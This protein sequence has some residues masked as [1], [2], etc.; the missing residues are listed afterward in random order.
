MMVRGVVKSMRAVAGETPAENGRP[1]Q[2]WQFL[3]LEVHDF[4]A[5][6][7]SCQLRHDDPKY[8]EYSPLSPKKPIQ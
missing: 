7:V 1:A 5:G 6:L 2:Q 3:S 4:T 8:K